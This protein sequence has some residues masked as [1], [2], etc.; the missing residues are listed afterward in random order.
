MSRTET[1]RALRSNLEK[2]SCCHAADLFSDAIQ[3]DASAGLAE[4]AALG[5]VKM[6][7]PFNDGIIAGFDRNQ[8]IRDIS[9]A[10]S[11]PEN[12]IYLLEN[13]DILADFRSAGQKT[14][15]VSSVTEDVS[16]EEDLQVRPLD[17]S[18]TNYGVTSSKKFDE[19]AKYQLKTKLKNQI[20]TQTG[21]LSPETQK[22]LDDIVELAYLSP[23]GAYSPTSDIGFV[24]CAIVH[25]LQTKGVT[26]ST[27]KYKWAALKIARKKALVSMTSKLFWTLTIIAVSGSAIFIANLIAGASTGALLG[28]PMTTIG[29]VAAITGGVAGLLRVAVYLLNKK[30]KP[31]SALTQT[32]DNIIPQPLLHDILVNSTSLMD[33]ID[34]KRSKLTQYKNIASGVLTLIGAAVIAGAS[35]FGI[36]VI[37]SVI[38]TATLTGWSAFI[39]LAAVATAALGLIMAVRGLSYAFQSID[40]HASRLFPKTFAIYTTAQEARTQKLTAIYDKILN[41]ANFEKAFTQ[42]TPDEHA[43]LGNYYVG[44][45]ANALTKD[46]KAHPN[47]APDQKNALDSQDLKIVQS[48]YALRASIHVE[49]HS[50]RHG[51]TSDT[52]LSKIAKALENVLNSDGCL[53]HTQALN[54]VFASLSDV[55]KTCLDADYQGTNELGAPHTRLQNDLSEK[56]SSSD[57][58]KALKLLQAEIIAQYNPEQT[59]FFGT[60]KNLLSSDRLKINGEPL[61]DTIG[62]NAKNTRIKMVLHLQQVDSSTA[63]TQA[64]NQVFASL[65]TDEKRC[66]DADYQGT[67]QQG[68]P[69]QRLQNDLKATAETMPRDM[70]RNTDQ[71]LS[72]LNANASAQNSI[73]STQKDTTSR[74]MATDKL[75]INNQTIEEH[76]AEQQRHPFAPEA[77]SEEDA[78]Q[79]LPIA[80]L[81]DSIQPSVQPAAT[82]QSGN[83][84]FTSG[85][86]TTA[87]AVP[88]ASL[89]SQPA[90]HDGTSVTA[91]DIALDKILEMLGYSK[92]GAAP[93]GEFLPADLTA[94]PEERNSLDN[95]KAALRERYLHLIDGVV[96]SSTTRDIT[97]KIESHVDYVSYWN[98]TPT[99]KSVNAPKD[100]DPK[101]LAIIARDNQAQI[102]ASTS[103]P[104]QP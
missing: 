9:L 84:L 87:A 4:K 26:V 66:L 16:S 96:Q 53:T 93:V 64:L 45:E 7:N 3:P 11:N 75:L 51:A 77:T 97:N 100:Q 68:P 80:L 27:K 20:K 52:T 54:Q 85:N 67:N 62:V 33:K 89:A 41:A 81:G 69:H 31:I 50:T 99:V 82:M 1:L 46:L 91:R 22:L 95:L 6:A 25:A 103:P 65:S 90:A 63:H 94:L 98:W 24:D 70:G 38:T 42:L 61:E 104:P 72:F 5:L 40:K 43:W 88:A 21:M 37:T 15:K 55:E 19:I 34:K 60:V 13:P 74:L 44:Q 102:E 49:G 83:D 18:P 59:A 92:D 23:G 39:A 101:T 35:Y 71:A 56:T 57:S 29:S 36:P 32:I 10:L 79:L 78:V 86:S 14:E 28:V 17:A 2:L 58:P 76:L 47:C 12:L 48:E 73:F 30:A 8:I